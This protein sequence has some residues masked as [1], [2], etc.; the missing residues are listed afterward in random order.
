ML[1]ADPHICETSFHVRYAETDAM[2][3]VHHAVYL[4]WFEEGRSAFIREQGWSYAEIERSGYF[5][6]ASDLRARYLRAARYDQRVTVRVWLAQVKSRQM[7]FQCE[8]VD[9]ASGECFFSASLKLLCLNR[10]GEITR[11]PPAWGAWLRE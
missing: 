11:I 3:F 9:S 6:V 1:Q 10:A 8:V 2:G 5:L 7:T 4:V